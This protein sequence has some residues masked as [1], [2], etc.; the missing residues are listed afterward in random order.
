MW[1]G[2]TLGVIVVL[3]FLVSLA[4]YNAGFGKRVE[5]QPGLKYFDVNEFPG[6]V[7]A[8]IH[9]FLKIRR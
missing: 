9:L 4:I 7:K 5:K 8:H 3:L 2:I 6:V 1:I